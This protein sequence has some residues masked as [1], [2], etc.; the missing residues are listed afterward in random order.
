MFEDFK[1]LNFDLKNLNLMINKLKN[2]W[3]VNDFNLSK[4]ELLKYLK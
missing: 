2:L 3:A 4:E 1:S